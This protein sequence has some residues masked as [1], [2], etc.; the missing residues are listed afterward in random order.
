ME[1]IPD[2]IKKINNG[3]IVLSTEQASHISRAHIGQGNRSALGQ[4][5]TRDSVFVL[6][7]DDETK[8]KLDE[9]E[10]KQAQ[11]YINGPGM[12]LIEGNGKRK[13]I[14]NHRKQV[15]GKVVDI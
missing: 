1:K 2:A 7:I 8:R 5:V 12:Y 3:D 11:E 15:E 9:K 14:N 6:E 4:W 10:V 13:Y